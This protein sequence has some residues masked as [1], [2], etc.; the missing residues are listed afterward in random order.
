MSICFLLLGTSARS[1]LAAPASSLP[2]VVTKAANKR[3]TCLGSP[4]CLRFQQS[5]FLH[6]RT[7]RCIQTPVLNARLNTTHPPIPLLPQTPAGTHSMHTRCARSVRRLSRVSTPR[8]MPRGPCLPVYIDSLDLL[9]P[10][11]AIFAAFSHRRR[12]WTPRPWGPFCLAASPGSSG[13]PS[14]G[15]APRHARPRS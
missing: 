13:R 15:R 3:H 10:A 14:P 6:S 11:A 1:F 2:G 7:Q 12:S 8:N 5:S 4:F 9:L